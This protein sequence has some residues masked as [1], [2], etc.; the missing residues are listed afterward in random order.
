MSVRIMYIMLN[1]I[2]I[3]IWRFISYLHEGLPAIFM[4]RLIYA[5]LS[6]TADLRN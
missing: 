4:M 6:V 3:I 1:W 5:G 2:G